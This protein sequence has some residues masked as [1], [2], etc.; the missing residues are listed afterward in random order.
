MAT[1]TTGRVTTGWLVAVYKVFLGSF[2]VAFIGVGIQAFYPEPRTPDALL[3]ANGPLPTELQPLA[4]AYQQEL[5]LYNRNVAIISA[6]AA[7]A[8]LALSLSA[9]RSIAV[10]S[11][12]F[13]LGGLLTFA[14]SIMR[15][16]GAE[17]NMVRFIIVSVGPIVAL[18]L[19]Y[20]RFIQ[21]IT[22]QP[23][24]RS[25]DGSQQSTSSRAA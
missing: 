20:A 7:I 6:V 11:D 25:A 12:G 18:G 1:Q 5:A 16:F 17:D 8:V 19:G 4:H 15:G 3:Y 9:L 24:L 14:Y 22:E 2:V 10:F 21:P 13:M 23:G